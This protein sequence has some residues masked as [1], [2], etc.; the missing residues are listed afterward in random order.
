[1]TRIVYLHGFASGPSSR[2]ARYFRER[3]EAAGASVGVP[4]LAEGGF[5]R[6]TT[7]GQP[8]L[9]FHGSRDE[10]VPAQCSR[11]FAAMR[12]NA[13]LEILDSG[14]DLLDA[15]EYMAPKAAA[16]LL[17]AAIP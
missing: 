4:D 13:R 2:K 1:M 9:L 15:L 16:F 10:V 11:E 3:L 5:D 8:A 17:P 12:S 6:L 14:H 7:T